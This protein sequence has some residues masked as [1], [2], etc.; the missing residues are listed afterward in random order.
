MVFLGVYSGFCGLLWFLVVFLGFYNGFEPLTTKT[1]VKT[2]KTH[3]NSILRDSLEIV[4]FLVFLVFTVVLVFCCGYW[5]FFVVFTL[6]LLVCRAWFLVVF[7]GFYSGFE[8]LTTKT[9]VK[10]QENP[11]NS[12]LRDSL[13]MVVFLV[14]LGFYSGFGGLLWSLV[15]VLGFYTGFGGLL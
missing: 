10:N 6:V 13:K 2:K 8:L 7:L 12:I 14:F 11:E 9:I 4:V 5:W 3:E 15:V 1:I